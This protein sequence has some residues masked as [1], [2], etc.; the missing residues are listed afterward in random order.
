MQTLQ[1]K[2]GVALSDN[3][4]FKTKKNDRDKGWW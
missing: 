4:D 1:N 2:Y 3:A